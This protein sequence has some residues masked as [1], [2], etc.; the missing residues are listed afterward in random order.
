MLGGIKTEIAIYFA[1]FAGAGLVADFA[2]SSR[3]LIAVASFF[4]YFFAQYLLY[5]AA[6]RKFGLLQDD[7]K[8]VPAFFG[9]ALFLGLPIIVGLNFFFIPGVILAAKW[10]MAPAVLV[11]RD[12]GLFE[13]IGVSWRE[14]DQNTVSLALAFAILFIMWLIFFA[15]IAAIDGMISPNF[16]DMGALGWISFHALP[17]LLLGLSVTA[18]R[19]LAD[20]GEDRLAEVF[21]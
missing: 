16:S 17:M 10:L 4:G 15:V 2:E 8:R 6:L 7:A 18:Y 20:E 11:A 13:A 5:Q 14:S 21:A 1:V 3:S 19:H 9:M 12:E